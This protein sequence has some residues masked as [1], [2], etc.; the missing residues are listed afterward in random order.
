MIVFADILKMLSE[1]GWSTYRL[2]KDGALSESVI[3]RLR[4]R[5]SIT[6]TT[7]DKICELCECQPGDLIRYI[8]GQQGE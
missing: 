2:R 6:T 7:I 4:N 5:D 1:H 3:T 8:P